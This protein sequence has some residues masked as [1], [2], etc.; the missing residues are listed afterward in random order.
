MAGRHKPCVLHEDGFDCWVYECDLKAPD[1][2]EWPLSLYLIG[3]SAGVIVV[4]AVLL[5]VWP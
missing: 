4:W 2:R 5:S 3:L 1:Y